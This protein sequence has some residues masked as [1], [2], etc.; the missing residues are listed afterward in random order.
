MAVSLLKILREPYGMQAG[1]KIG[2]HPQVLRHQQLLDN[3]SSVTERPTSQW[4]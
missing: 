4:L 3:L 1:K 2:E